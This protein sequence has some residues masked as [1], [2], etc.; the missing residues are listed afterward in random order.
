LVLENIKEMRGLFRSAS[1]MFPSP[2]IVKGLDINPISPFYHLVTNNPPPHVKHL[3]RVFSVNE[4]ERDL[5]YLLR[6]YTPIDARNLIQY[7]NLDLEL[8]KP[9]IF[10]SFDDGYREVQDIIS[11]I[12]LRK[13]IPAT[14]FVNPAHVG[15][16]DLMYRCKISLIIDKI[17]KSGISNSMVAGLAFLLKTENDISK[18]RR[19]LIQ[20]KSS[21]IGIITKI[22]EMVDLNFND[23]LSKVQ[24]YVT[25]SDLHTLENSG[26]T[27]GGHG[28]NHPY[29]NEISYKDQLSE[30]ERCMQW[31]VTN[32]P[33]QP[34]LFAFPFTDFGVSNDL[35]EQMV[36]G[37]D[38]LCDVSFG[39][40]GIQPPRFQRHL[41]RVPMEV[42]V[43]S[44]QRVVEG[45]ILYYI[46]KKSLGYYRATH[47]KHK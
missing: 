45:E 22:A 47:D 31:I 1:R 28:Y 41:Q 4:F 15:N 25:L 26:F 6:Y 9:T 10:L 32:F 17:E 46:V 27:I 24:P 33:N 44:A 42:K 20:L 16:S 3:Y 5:E 38:N 39:T 23:Y 11:P 21:Q 43:G 12:L 36:S 34:K 19:N 35:L 7:L 14:F 40:A 29:F 18:I 13:G 8:S 37:Q 30:V 2:I